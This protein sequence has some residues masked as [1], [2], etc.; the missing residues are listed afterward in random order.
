MKHLTNGQ[1][2]KLRQ[3]FEYVPEISY[4]QTEKAWTIRPETKLFGTHLA[5]EEPITRCTKHVS[6]GDRPIWRALYADGVLG[7][8][9]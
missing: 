6:N 7:E 2:R 3:K 5:G 9:K 4:I 1:K 8:P